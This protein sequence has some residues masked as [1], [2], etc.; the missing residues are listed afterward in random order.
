MH[1]LIVGCRRAK[2]NKH[3]FGD[4]KQGTSGLAGGGTNYGLSDGLCGG[5]SDRLQ[6]AVYNTTRINAAYVSAALAYFVF[7]NS[8]AARWRLRVMARFLFAKQLSN[9]F[10]HAF[11]H[12]GVLHS[13]HPN[14]PTAAGTGGLTG[15]STKMQPSALDFCAI[16]V[17]CEPSLASHTR[18]LGP[19]NSDHSRPNSSHARRTVRAS[20]IWCG[21]FRGLYS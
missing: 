18:L 14:R 16:A 10:I 6:A 5:Y 15:Q 12:I 20:R 7:V 17:D 19:G 21:P 3:I 4:Q 8:L 11:S 1:D 2:E 9:W 13:G